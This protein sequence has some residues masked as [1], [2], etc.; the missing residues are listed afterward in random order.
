MKN[1]NFFKYVAVFAAFLITLF[2]AGCG[3][4]DDDKG[5]D[6]SIPEGKLDNHAGGNAQV[7]DGNGGNIDEFFAAVSKNISTKYDN[8]TSC[9]DDCI[10]YKGDFDDDGY[11]IY[12][13]LSYSE[14]A[15]GTEDYKYSY[16]MT[17]EYHK[18]FE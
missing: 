4:D 5:G 2:V 16:V 7:S 3:D 1:L 6:T 17:E 8:R 13:E 18:L 10:R 9:G 15:S 11:K 12:K 14:Q